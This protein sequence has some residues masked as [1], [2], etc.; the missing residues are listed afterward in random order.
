MWQRIAKA[1]AVED[2]PN[3]GKGRLRAA[4]TR[5]L[6]VD[7]ILFVFGVE[8]NV[9]ENSSETNY[10]KVNGKLVTRGIRLQMPNIKV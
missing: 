1:A 5:T 4:L 6:T 10:N 8:N 7:G 3:I 9:V 2:R